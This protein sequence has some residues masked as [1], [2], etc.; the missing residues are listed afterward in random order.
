MNK[1][2]RFKHEMKQSFIRAYNI[3][4]EDKSDFVELLILNVAIFCS[5]GSF[6]FLGGYGVLLFAMWFFHVIANDWMI[7]F[8]IIC[9]LAV[10]IGIPSA[11]I[12]LGKHFKANE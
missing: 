9:S 11:V 4:I 2:Q 1:Y 5:I 3:W 6:L 12:L 8:Y 7:L 10:I